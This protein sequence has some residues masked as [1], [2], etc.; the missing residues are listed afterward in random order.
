M[1]ESV[2]MIEGMTTRARQV[3]QIVNDAN[4]IVE[5]SPCEDTNMES[6]PHYDIR[7]R[8]PSGDSFMCIVLT[9]EQCKALIPVFQN[10]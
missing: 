5:I 3:T 6:N 2:G 7:Y 8:D 1:V 9:K 4:E 10:L